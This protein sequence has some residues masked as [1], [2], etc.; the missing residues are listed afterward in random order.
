MNSKVLYDDACPLCRALAALVERRAE[1]MLDFQSWQAY[2]QQGSGSD[3][4]ALGSLP[5]DAIP[6]PDRIHIVVD[7]Q[8]IAGVAAWE[9]IVALH[10]DFAGLSWMASRLG[11]SREI[12]QVVQ[13]TAK[14]LRRFC[15]RCPR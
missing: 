14:F 9:Y 2:W 5:P 11:L 1:G 4:G 7:G 6:P 15:R 10:P 8:I 3:L 13:S 12:A